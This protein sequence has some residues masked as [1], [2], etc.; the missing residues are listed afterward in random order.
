MRRRTKMGLVL[1]ASL[2]VALGLGCAVLTQPIGAGRRSGPAIEADPA[3]LEATV[4]ALVERFGPRDVDHPENLARVASFLAGELGASGAQVELQPFE[5]EGK[6]Y[7]NVAARFGP[8]DGPRLVVGAHYDTAGPLPGADDNASGVAGLLELARHLGAR[9]PDVPI[10]LVAY[11][12]EEPPV[13]KTS[14]MG[15]AVH[16]DSLAKAGVPVRAMLSLEMIGCFSDAER[17]QDYP[18]SV[19]RPLYPSRGDFIAV[20]G[21]LASIP[22]VRRVKAAM[23]G[24]SSL[25]ALSMNAP[26]LVRGV[27]FSDHRNYWTHGWPAA[28]VTDTAF[29]R[30]PRY[31]EPQDTPE[32]L[33]YRRM[34]LVVQGVYSAVGALAEP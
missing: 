11:T 34:A 13:Y 16:A 31:H 2:L 3:R 8:R 33:D 21:D 9:R 10:E 30:N 6:E 12:L 22:L 18:L 29:N 5:R 7:A 32:T 1:L 4:R 27:S 19:L 17:S 14:S 24:A 23:R 15:S 26:R 25:P 28:M 20:V